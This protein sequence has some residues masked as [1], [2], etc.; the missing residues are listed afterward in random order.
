[1]GFQIFGHA[2]PAK[3]LLEKAHLLG[4]RLVAILAE[5]LAEN[6]AAE[7]HREVEAGLGRV[8]GIVPLQP[9]P[10]HVIIVEEEVLLRVDKFWQSFRGDAIG[11]RFLFPEVPDGEEIQIGLLE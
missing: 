6:R 8:V 9:D 10:G 1:M 4:P 7:L 2:E 3:V 5:E 11:P